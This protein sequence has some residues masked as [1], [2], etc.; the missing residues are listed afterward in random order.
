[1]T[2]ELFS[3]GFACNMASELMCIP[4][5]LLILSLFQGERPGAD[6]LDRAD[7]A[8]VDLGEGHDAGAGAAHAGDPAAAGA[9]QEGEGGAAALLDGLAGGALREV[10]DL[11]GDVEEGTAGEGGDEGVEEE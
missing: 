10:E 7:G 2:L 9:G 3:T 4:C 11:Q 1:M 5:S 6:A 8:R